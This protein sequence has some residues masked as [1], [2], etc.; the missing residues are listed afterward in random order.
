[1]IH[2][3]PPSEQGIES[4]YEIVPGIVVAM[5]IEQLRRAMNPELTWLTWAGSASQFPVRFCEQR[6]DR[7]VGYPPCIN[8]DFLPRILFDFFAFQG[9]C[10]Y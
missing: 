8:R 9:L 4:H 6:D 7:R 3:D 5:Y 2:L 1:M 10:M